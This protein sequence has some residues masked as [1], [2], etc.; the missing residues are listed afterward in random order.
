[1]RISFGV[2]LATGTLVFGLASPAAAQPPTP[3]TGE[4]LE[5]HI[6]GQPTTAAQ[7]TANTDGSTSYSFSAAGPATGPYNGTYT[8]TINVTV[9]AQTIPGTSRPVV[10][11]N[12]APGTFFT[13]GP[14]VTLTSSFTIKAFDGRTVTG[15]KRLVANA[16]AGTGSCHQFVNMASQF[17]PVTGFYKDAE[18]TALQYTASI[19]SPEGSATDRGS[20]ELQVRNGFITGGGGQVFSSVNDFVETFQSTQFCQEDNNRQGNDPSCNNTGNSQ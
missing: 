20:S 11:F 17:G 10:P 15:T 18:S 8:E 4:K 1:M 12:P 3:L 7:C 13:A 9:G 5:Q 19:Q 6:L 14:L 16:P 2:A